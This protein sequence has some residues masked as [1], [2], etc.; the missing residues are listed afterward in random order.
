MRYNM[1]S[2]YTKNLS[3]QFLIALLKKHGITQVIASP[4]TT[5]L[6]FVA[7]LQYDGSFNIIS[8]VD[9]RSAS[10]M[11]YGMA[12]ESKKPV[13]ITCTEA[14]A[15]RDYFPGLTAA[16]YIHL[17]ILA[18]TGVHRYNQIGQLRPQVIDRSVSPNDLFVHKEQ[19]PVIKDKEDETE[20]Q[21]RINRAILALMGR[22]GGTVHIDLP[23]CNDDYD[24]TQKSLPEV[25]VIR[26]YY[27]NMESPKITDG[28][29]AI[30]IGSHKSFSQE[31]TR[32]IDSFCAQYDAVVFCDHTSSYY[33]KY[34]IKPALVSIQ[35]NN[36][37]IFDDIELLIH[38]G[39]QAADGSTPSKLKRAKR[40]WRVNP[41]GE[42][43]DTFGKLE[44]VFA[45]DERIFFEQYLNDSDIN[46]KENYLNMCKKLMN[47]VQVSVEALPFSNVYIAAVISKEIPCDST[48]YLGPSNTIRAWAFFEFPAGVKSF[49][50]VGCRGI[51]GV[52]ASCVGSSYIFPERIHFCILGDLTFF[53]DINSIVANK[54][55]S[56]IR[57]LLVNNG[58][59]SIFKLS[60]APAY[61]Y[62]GDKTADEY[63]A[64]GG[65][66]GN[67]SSDLIMH[68]TK[69]L[70][71]EY[72]CA[73][74]KEEFLSKYKKFVNPEQLEKPVLFEVF[75]NAVDERVAF[76]IMSQ[77][78]A[79]AEGKAK[80]MVKQMLGNQVSN[81]LKKILG[82]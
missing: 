12:M 71:F 7:G 25:R 40:V 38:L 8:C 28:R 33:G 14:T 46:K 62:F 35:S 81:K 45:M 52:L 32:A 21:L 44:A 77:L 3:V 61:K 20:T 60:G 56:N 79:S 23:C 57:I 30:Y 72:M 78:D 1:I 24:F 2:G 49:G 37:N 53:Y 26:R 66:F 29:I 70:G 19:L 68:L 47:R 22:G 16:Y 76:N 48:I 75:T 34:C 54:F 50:N 59:G 73:S 74:T 42:L 6:E 27:P 82:K 31:E 63:I 9:E 39:E 55:Q 65:H 36:Y 11:A 58:G 51:D 43:R 64:A 4:G 41:D 5:N 10:Y 80:Y 17:P 69:G 67:K 15:S 18:V 13:V